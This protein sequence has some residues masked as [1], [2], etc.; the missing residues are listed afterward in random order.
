MNSNQIVCITNTVS[1]ALENKKLY[2]LMPNQICKIPTCFSLS[3]DL[4]K[5]SQFFTFLSKRLCKI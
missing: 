4:K 2:N 3:L 5:T 1:S